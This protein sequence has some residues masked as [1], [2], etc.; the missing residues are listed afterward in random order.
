MVD[1]RRTTRNV[2]AVLV[3]GVL[4]SAC[5]GGSQSSNSSTG[6]AASS[7]DGVASAP[8]PAARAGEPRALV[9]EDPGFVER[10]AKDATAP[11]TATVGRVLA[12]DRNIVY[13]G[14]VTVRVKDVGAAADAAERLVTGANGVL[15]AE[16]TK[17]G[18]GARSSSSAHLTLRVPPGDFRRVLRGLAA[19]GTPVSQTQTAQDVTGQVVDT[20]S[21]LATQRRSVERVRVLLGQAKTIGEVV[22]VESELSRREADLES[23][24]AQLAQLKDVTDLA[25][26]E[27]DLLARTTATATR[28]DDAGFVAGLRSG[29]DAISGLGVVALTAAG[30]S[31]PFLVLLALL[32]LPAWRL[33]RSLRGR[34][35]PQPAPEATTTA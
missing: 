11:A 30:A 14:Q 9:G 23:M 27:A 29:W 4:L 34:A 35:H 18:S 21:R 28:P 26:I 20:T 8:S 3:A 17:N 25:S 10:Q 32:G 2:L 16:S 22:Q 5:S 15:F 12:P 31:L 7:S 33:A 1:P 19:L 6:P 13:R 24:Q